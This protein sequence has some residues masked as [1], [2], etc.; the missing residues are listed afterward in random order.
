MALPRVF[1]EKFATVPQPT[2]GFIE[3]KLPTYTELFG[4]RFCQT[5]DH[6]V[7]WD[8]HEPYSWT[9]TLNAIPV[10]IKPITIALSCLL[11]GGKRI[12]HPYTR[13]L[14]KSAFGWLRLVAGSTYRDALKWS[15]RQ[16]KAA[17]R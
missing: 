3:Y 10:E 14:P 11:P 8:D 17:F 15:G 13:P 5:L 12:F 7:W 6:K 1:F 2:L 16:L 4:I 9:H